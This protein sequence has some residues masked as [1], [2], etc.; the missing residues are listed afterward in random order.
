MMKPSTKALLLG[1]AVAMTPALRGEDSSAP[2]VTTVKA[3]KTTKLLDASFDSLAKVL[4]DSRLQ[5]VEAENQRKLALEELDAR[6]KA[7]AETQR[8]LADLKRQLAATQK[9]EANWKNESEKLAKKLAAGEEAHANLAKFR[10]Q[11]A[12]TLEEFAS[13]KGDIAQVR[14]ELEAP[15]ERVALRKQNANLIAENGKLKKN[16]RDTSQ[17]LANERKQHADVREQLSA[18]QRENAILGNTVADLEKNNLKLTAQLKEN[19][20]ALS[21]AKADSQEAIQDSAMLEKVAAR[22]Q[23][24]HSNMAKSLAEANLARDQAQQQLASVEAARKAATENASQ[25]GAKLQSANTD[26]DA[27]RREKADL[28]QNIGK[29]A[30]A[31]KDAETKAKSV[32]ATASEQQKQIAALR[33]EATRSKDA[34]SAMDQSSKTEITKLREE[35]S[36]SNAAMMALESDTQELRKI[37]GLTTERLKQTKQQI[38]AIEEEKQTLREALKKR[39]SEIAQLQASLDKVHS[40]ET[41]RNGETAE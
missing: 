37:S 33:T 17:L 31:L 14:G 35:L 40:K 16:L 20:Y 34:L 32:S 19:T 4:E 22:L 8:E 15:A 38:R 11:M 12:N 25:L 1:L 21:A 6:R 9:S 2:A 18:T 30:K 10:D 28:V 24:E 26:L 7:H 5:V 29:Q 23:H 36:K 41:A 13:L 27:L 3:D 39:E